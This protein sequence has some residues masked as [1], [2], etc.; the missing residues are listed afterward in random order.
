MKK[1]VA[2]WEKKGD[3]KAKLAD[4]YLDGLSWHSNDPAPTFWP[5]IPELIMNSCYVAKCSLL[6]F[7]CSLTCFFFKC[8][9]GASEKVESRVIRPTDVYRSK[10]PIAYVDWTQ[11]G[12]A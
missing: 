3:K 11:K 2:Y 4:K 6:L 5:K 10:L 9:V 1:T 7:F 12:V 8:C